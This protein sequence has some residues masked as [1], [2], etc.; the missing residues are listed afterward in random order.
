MTYASEADLLNVSLFGKTAGQWRKEHPKAKGNIRDDASLEQLVVLSNLESINALLIRQ[1]MSQGERLVLLNK[2]A[3]TQL[4]S[5]IGNRQIK[6]L[7]SADVQK[8][9]R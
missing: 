7:T 2:T 9:I 6:R 4:K 8:K 5:L 3:I 1:E